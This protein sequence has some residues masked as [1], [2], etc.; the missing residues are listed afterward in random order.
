M[1]N[2]TLS[3]QT[4]AVG[5]GHAARSWATCFFR[6][7]SFCFTPAEHPSSRP[8]YRHAARSSR[9]GWRA[10]SR[11][12]KGLSLTARTAAPL[13][14]K[15]G[16]AHP[17]QNNEEPSP[18]PH[19]PPPHRQPDRQRHGNRP[20]ASAAAASPGG[21]RHGATSGRRV[22][23]ARTAPK[24]EVEGRA[25]R[26]TPGC[27]RSCARLSVYRVDAEALAAIDPDVILTQT[28]ARCARS[29][30]PTWRPTTCTWTGRP[31]KSS[32]SGPT[33]WPMPMPTSARLPQALAAPEGGDA[34][35]ADAAAHRRRRRPVA[36]HPG[37]A[38]PSSSGSSR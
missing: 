22:A 5:G 34:L 4:Q 37:R 9:R 21:R 15:P 8:P 1:Q 26:S 12:P 17:P 28:T 30:S 27:A 19:T 24:F 31:V 38:S 25:P 2:K 29:A 3:Q 23:S 33:R 6:R 36:G 16:R 20:R 14:G 10:W 18:C 11:H 13:G 32:R 35:V 7:C